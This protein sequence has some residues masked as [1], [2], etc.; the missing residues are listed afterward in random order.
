MSEK[1]YVEPPKKNE[2]GKKEYIKPPKRNEDRGKEY[3]KPPKRNEGSEKE[4]IKPPKRNEG[5]EKEYIK[6]P[7]RNEG[8]EKE[9]IKPPKRDED[10]NKYANRQR[11]EGSGRSNRNRNAGISLG[12]LSA[13]FCTPKVGIKFYLN[14][15]I[16]WIIINYIIIRNTRGILSKNLCNLVLIYGIFS[17]YAYSWY[18]DYR[19][20]KGGF[21]SYFFTPLGSGK[22]ATAAAAI[23]EFF[24]LDSDMAE[25]RGKIKTG[26]GEN[27]ENAR[28]KSFLLRTILELLKAMIIF[29]FS[30][31][32]VVM[33]PDTIRK[34]AVAV[35]RNS[36]C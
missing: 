12:K 23:G 36:N 17:N 24:A 11:T 18:A 4:Y 6:P 7:K 28:K 15:Y 25:Y 1:G 5:S 8:S 22:V 16:A 30:I 13:Y 26:A 29:P 32:L 20:Y 33:H 14:G 19:R 9:Y 3:I 10:N 35:E 2:D 27:A 31:I 34:Y 21:L